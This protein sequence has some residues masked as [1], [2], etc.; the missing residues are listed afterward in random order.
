MILSKLTL[1]SNSYRL[2][3]ESVMLSMKAKYAL[4]ALVVLAKNRDQR[5]RT[6]IIA[7]RMGAPHKFLEAILT[8]LKGHGIVTS[9][10]GA[11]G[12]VSLA[13]KGS[14]ISVADIV[15]IIDGPLAPIRCASLTAYRKCDD[16]QDE[17]LCSIR[18]VM[19]DARTALSKALEKRS[20]ED[21]A[22]FEE[23][24]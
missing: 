23:N 21:M 14:A 1:T 12:G 16:C 18:N 17:G 8:E 3:R 24:F 19:W 9:R 6:K 4:K 2:S 13:K 7:E 10:R 20:I 11:D 5:M 15:R 22:R